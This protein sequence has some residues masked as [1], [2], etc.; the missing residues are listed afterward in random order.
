MNLEDSSHFD[1]HGGTSDQLKEIL[2]NERSPLVSVQRMR[3]PYNA[4]HIAHA[5]QR[6]YCVRH[7]PQSP[8]DFTR[9]WLR[10]VAASTSCHFGARRT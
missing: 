8:R 1:A 6:T 3:M 10:L 5:I 9:L 2:R 4:R 7:A